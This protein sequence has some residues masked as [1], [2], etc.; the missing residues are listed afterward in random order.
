M[1]K[2]YLNL[3]LYMFVSLQMRAA[4]LATLKRISVIGQTHRMMINSTG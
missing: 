2:T 1:N 4:M 3:L